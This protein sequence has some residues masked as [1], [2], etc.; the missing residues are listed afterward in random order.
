MRYPMSRLRLRTAV[1]LFNIWINLDTQSGKNAGC[2]DMINRT[3]Y[4]LC[5]CPA[6]N[7][8]RYRI[9]GS[10]FLRSEGLEKVKVS[11]LLSLVAN[12]GLGLAGQLHKPARRYNGTVIIYVSIGAVME[13]LSTCTTTVST[14]KTRFNIISFL[15][16]GLPSSLLPSDIPNKTLHAPFLSPIRA[17]H[18]VLLALDLVSRII[19]AEEYKS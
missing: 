4:T 17:I 9:W 8:K 11:S 12:T 15:R 18:P 10:M 16:L 5:H 2:I 19:S 14:T 3:L 6:L 1:G 7:V 13:S